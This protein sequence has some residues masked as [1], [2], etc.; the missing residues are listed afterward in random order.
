MSTTMAHFVLNIVQD[1]GYLL[2]VRAGDT[3]SDALKRTIQ[4]YGEQIMPIEISGNLTDLTLS[5]DA[6]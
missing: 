5:I 1:G 2:K 3:A 6:K 4:T